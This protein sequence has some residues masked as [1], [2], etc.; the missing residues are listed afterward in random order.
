VNPLKGKK[1]TKYARPRKDEQ[2]LVL[3]AARIRFSPWNRRWS[4]ST[5]MNSSK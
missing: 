3:D 5:T 4:S 2:A 1:L